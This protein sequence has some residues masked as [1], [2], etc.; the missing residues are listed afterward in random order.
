MC[1]GWRRYIAEM[2]FQST[3]DIACIGQG[4]L[5]HGFPFYRVIESLGVYKQKIDTH[6]GKSFRCGSSRCNLN[7]VMLP[8][9][10]AVEMANQFVCCISSLRI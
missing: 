4:L 7:K 9:V 5:P 2:C 8:P 10:A 3:Q 1:A 6:G